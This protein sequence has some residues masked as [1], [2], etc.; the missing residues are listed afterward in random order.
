ME[1]NASQ[2][3]IIS[4]NHPKYIV[5]DTNCFIDNLDGIMRIIDSRDFDIILPLIGMFRFLTVFTPIWW[6]SISNDAVVYC[7]KSSEDQNS[8]HYRQVNQSIKIGSAYPLLVVKGNYVVGARKS[9]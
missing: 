6:N 5:P 1:S 7:G 2:V 9:I 4:E 3:H 8:K